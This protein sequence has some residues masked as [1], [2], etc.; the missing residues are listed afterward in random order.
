MAKTMRLP[1]QLSRRK[2]NSHKN[3][4]GHVLILAGSKR[5]L[6]AAALTSHATIRSGAGL[7]TLGIPRS[8]NTAI[9]KKIPN[10]VMTWPLPET[11]AQSLSFS[12]YLKIKDYFTKYSLIALGPGLST[13]PST[14]KLVLKIIENAPLPIVV[15]A[16]ALNALAGHLSSLKKS[17][18]SKILTPH[19][20]EMSRLINKPRK[21]IQEHRAQ[22]AKDFSNKHNCTLLLK[23]HRT[24][25]VSKN[26][27][28][29]VNTTGNA[30]MATGGSG[31]VLT[32][33]IAA[34]MAQG[35]SGYDAAKY[36]AFIH[37]RAGDLAAKAKTQTAMIASDII[38]NIPTAI[39]KSK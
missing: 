30:G 37:G 4:F 38:V 8:L 15:D 18:S 10:E 27:R 13:E 23:G 20:G 39:K 34:F 25:V 36:G 19:P 7:V 29:H 16:D 21:H 11:P 3:D 5:M 33:I 17:K 24:I 22:I 6:G 14:Q 32:G 9:Q 35:L 31:D 26:K 12:A 2:K 28:L 1:T